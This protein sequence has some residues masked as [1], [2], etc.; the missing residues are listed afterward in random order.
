M[1]AMLLLVRAIR[2]KH[3]GRGPL[4]Q[5][6]LSGRGRPVG[7]SPTMFHIHSVH[8]QHRGMMGNA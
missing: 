2:E 8:C 5:G 4:L 1:P 3:R 7:A 6:H